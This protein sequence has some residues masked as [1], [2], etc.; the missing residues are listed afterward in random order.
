MSKLPET[1]NYIYDP[2]LFKQNF[3]NITEVPS[4]II[5]KLS[6]NRNNMEI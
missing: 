3:V 5:Q 1:L 2:I 4:E 6:I